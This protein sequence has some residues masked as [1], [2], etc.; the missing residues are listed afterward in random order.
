M[1]STPRVGPRPD[2]GDILWVVHDFQA[3]T[4]DELTLIKG[5]LIELIE[6][7]DEF[8]DRWYLGR[9]MA[10]GN[11]GLFPEAYTQPAP[12]DQLRG[13]AIKPMT[14]LLEVSSA[15]DTQSPLSSLDD[16][17]ASAT[18]TAPP[19]TAPVSESPTVAAAT[20]VSTMG[21]PS[22]S[23]PVM[24]PQQDSQ[25]LHDTLNVIDEHIT[26][27]RS[28]PSIG[29]LNAGNDSGSEYSTQ[30]D[31]RMSYIHGEE[32][33]EEEAEVPHTRAEIMRWG[34][35]DV[36]EYLFT[37]GVE[38]HHCEVFRDQEIAGE[39][40]LEMDQSSLFIKDFDL[41][42]VGRRLKTWSKVKAL[43]DEVASAQ[44]PAPRRSAT[45]N[46]G[47]EAGSEHPRSRSRANTVTSIG[48]SDER[49]SSVQPKHI[50]TTNTLSSTRVGSFP[51]RSAPV[52]AG[53]PDSPTHYKRPSAASI[54]D[55]N[56]NRNSFSEYRSPSALS[57]MAP[58]STSSS[59]DHRKQ[60]SFDR[61]WT[62]GGAYTSPRPLSSTG[63]HDI[64]AQSQKSH[65]SA[66]GAVP[67]SGVEMDRGY[68]S[69]TEGETKRSLKSM[70]KKRDSTN[71]AS[72]T[73]EQR[74]RS[75]TAMSRHSR[76]GSVDLPDGGQTASQKY[77]AIQGGNHRKTNSTTTTD[78][79]LKPPPPA[80][81]HPPVVT[82]LD[83]PTT[84]TAPISPSSTNHK[85]SHDWLSAMKPN[86]RHSGSNTGSG[87]RAISDSVSSP[88]SK[89]ASTAA[90]TESSPLASP[91]TR[92]GSSTASAGR[93][94]EL[95]SPDATK[96]A[97]ASTVSGNSRTNVKKKN[98]QETSAYQRGLLKISPREA[99]K[100]ADYSGWMK[101]KSSNLMT[102]W[103]PRFFI[104]KGRRLSY[105]YSE[106]DD[107]EKGL[108]DISFH[109]VLPADNERL[110]G[111]HATLTGAG[112]ASEG[113]DKGDDS[114]FIFKLT[115]P[116]A[117]LSRAVNFTKPTVHYFAVPNLG[118]GRLWMAALMKA[119]IERDD[120]QPVT[121]S[122]QQKTI[123]LAKARQQRHRPPEL[124]DES[125]V[126]KAED[127]N[128]ALA[129][130]AATQPG[131]VADVGAAALENMV[132]QSA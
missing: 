72:Y 91:I 47:S 29:A 59:N 77:Y 83:S 114:M 51:L 60:P 126:A 37:V 108:I 118:Q 55:M 42:S 68:F 62:M 6:R 119:T 71:G 58:P 70:F 26:N 116:R 39:V 53:M 120:T 86:H 66:H 57:K 31:H 10:N 34:P 128:A 106:D 13:H 97:G 87:L 107:Q 63:I 74:V 5:D 100:D 117:G 18:T 132:P 19:A 11:T 46:Y 79:S 95:D 33:D 110:T 43:Q 8:G 69:G 109:R 64:L 20:G 45:S 9:H 32:T 84:A 52:S 76:Y 44:A 127:K 85:T 112:N 88:F 122:Y 23:T 123:S 40:L 89:F 78:S 75:A 82:K 3:R 25:V 80:K 131:A 65:T 73:E 4:S 90:A 105:Y 111:L 14:P 24:L 98:K 50:V 130:A 125:A 12:K 94:F 35:D 36:A 102:T 21:I 38:K 129:A 96:S 27:L 16:A 67:D 61:N 124:R 28:P 17:A 103:K 104:L 113:M 41:G 30:Y 81:D 92:T 99:M 1:M 2:V 15:T 48:R 93:S 54:R 101:K 7:D 121:T 56:H 115:P 22:I 49:P